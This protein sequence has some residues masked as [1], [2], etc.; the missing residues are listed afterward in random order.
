MVMCTISHCL[1]KNKGLLIYA[2][3][4]FVSTET[5]GQPYLRE[6]A[7]ELTMTINNKSEKAD[8]ILF[9]IV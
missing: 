7:H 3:N 5:E 6:E 2:L 9:F 4:F 1:R 8:K